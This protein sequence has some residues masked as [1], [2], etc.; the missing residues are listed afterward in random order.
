MRTYLT[1]TFQGKELQLPI[2]LNREDFKQIYDMVQANIKFTGWEKPEEEGDVCFYQDALSR[3]QHLE[4]NEGSKAEI[5]LLYE[6][7]NCY[8]SETLAKNICRAD[9]LFNKLRKIAISNRSK[10]ISFT[11]TGGYTIVYNYSNNCLEVGMTGTYMG[12]GDVLFET[13]EAARSAINENA[14]ELIWYFTEMSYQV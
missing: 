9:A 12:F 11:K 10:P 4:L 5:D 13:E 1:V 14:E 6:A 3:V 8:S 7:S 2:D